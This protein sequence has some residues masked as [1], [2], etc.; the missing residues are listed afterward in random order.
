LLPVK[1]PVD[2]VPETARLPDQ[3]PEAVQEAASVEPQLSVEALP[4]LIDAGA[5]VSDTVGTGS[6]VTATDA[7]ALPPRPVHV[8]EYVLLAVSAPVDRVPEVPLAP[9]QSPEAVQDPALVEDQA[10]TEAEPLGT[11]PGVA[12]NVTVGGD[13]GRARAVTATWVVALAL[14]PGPEH[15]SKNALFSLSAPVDSVP[16]TAR[17]PDQAPEATHEV[18]FVADHLS[19]DASPLASVSGL[20]P[21]D[22]VGSSGGAEPCVVSTD[23]L[24]QAVSAARK[25]APTRLRV[26]RSR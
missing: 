12:V 23:L 16:E 20:T 4:L 21:N 8:S 26:H 24:P 6:T 15:L 5:A 9:D 3:S 2:S 13:G 17:G 11:D 25:T 10:S 1:T 18:A 14:P 19:V 7:L 22:T